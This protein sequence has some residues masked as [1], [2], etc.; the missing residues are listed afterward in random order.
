MR[1]PFVLLFKNRRADLDAK[2]GGGE[3]PS[4]LVKTSLSFAPVIFNERLLGFA[5]ISFE[6][7]IVPM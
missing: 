7:R 1:N 6:F 2:N 5:L 4:Q 3:N